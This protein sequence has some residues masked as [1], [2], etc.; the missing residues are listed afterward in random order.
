MGIREPD[1]PLQTSVSHLRAIREVSP[2]VYESARIA[3][4]A[5]MALMNGGQDNYPSDAAVTLTVGTDKRFIRATGTLTA[6]RAWTLSTAGATAGDWFLITRTSGGAFNLNVGTGPLK[7]LAQ[8]TWGVFVF[9]EAG[10]WYLAMYG[11]L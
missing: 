10:A 7:A 4:A 11:A 1:I 5:L 6:D 3:L 2:G 8:N 9:D